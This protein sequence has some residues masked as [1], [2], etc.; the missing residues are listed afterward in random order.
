MAQHLHSNAPPEVVVHTL[1]ARSLSLV[2]GVARSLSLVEGVAS[3]LV[4]GVACQE[5][6]PWLFIAKRGVYQ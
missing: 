1:V 3:T 5:E 4:E 6:L 2:E